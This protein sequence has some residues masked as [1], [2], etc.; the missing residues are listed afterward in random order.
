MVNSKLFFKF[1]KQKICCLFQV[2]I[3][4]NVV[5]EDDYELEGDE[6]SEKGKGTFKGLGSNQRVGIQTRG[7]GSNKLL[8]WKSQL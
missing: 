1:Y 6:E 4:C 5:S 7:L 8:G 3:G 2:R